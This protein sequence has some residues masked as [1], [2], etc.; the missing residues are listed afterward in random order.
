MLVHELRN[1][2]SVIRLK[3]S[4]NSSG[5]K[6]VH[7]AVLEMAQIIERVEQSETLDHADAPSQRTRVDLGSVLRETAAEH[8]ASSRMGIDAPT[9]L[10]VETDEDLL[11]RILK[12]LLENAWKYSPDASSIVLAASDKSHD[13]IDG[14]Q[15]SI[16]NEAGEA[17]FPDAGKL[18]T[19]YY[20]SKG[21]H[22]R[23]GSGLGL[24]LVA[25]W[26]KA[27]GGTVRYKEVTAENGN[28]LLC[29]SLWLPK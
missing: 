27:L 21:A 1:P 6:A 9:G 12:T 19:K 5:G 23:P 2:L 14:V 4:E 29:F 11:R 20:R 26:A 7:Q 24:F 18:F 17:G 16:L 10:V 13:G 3:T 22:R 15:L 8:P 28:P 25:S